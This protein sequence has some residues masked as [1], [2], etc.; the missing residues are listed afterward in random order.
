MLVIPYEYYEGGRSP[1][2]SIHIDSRLSKKVRKSL[3]KFI[4]TNYES[5]KDEELGQAYSFI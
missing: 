2:P 4:V 3:M 1:N 5:M